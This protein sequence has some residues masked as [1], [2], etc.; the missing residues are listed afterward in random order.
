M[1]PPASCPASAVILAARQAK[2]PLA[3]ATASA[4]TILFAND[5][6]AA[7]VD[8]EAG[9]LVGR[10]L[11][12]I[13]TVVDEQSASGVA[14]RRTLVDSQG[15]SATV[16][17]STAA[18]AG[19]D[20]SPSC[21]LCSLIDAHGD[22]ADEAIAREAALLAEVAQAA[23]DLMRESAAAAD[24]TPAATASDIA[25]DAIAHATEHG[26]ASRA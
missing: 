8:C 10:P 14:T 24:L 12:S 3:I 18:V 26:T 17:L 5:A 11:A 20:G 9:D 15:R 21:L 13:G 22:G 7:L 2:T 4:P 23:G 25:F 1:T 19:P 16:A 6:F